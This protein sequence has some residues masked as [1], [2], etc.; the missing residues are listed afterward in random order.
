MEATSIAG[1]EVQQHC[2][3]APCLSALTTWKLPPAACA[4]S[5]RAVHYEVSVL[6]VPGGTGTATAGR[7]T[8]WAHQTIPAKTG[9]TLLVY[10]KLLQK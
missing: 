1:A 9:Y 2:L 8:V 6:V 5:S 4:S 10:A 3:T 7:W